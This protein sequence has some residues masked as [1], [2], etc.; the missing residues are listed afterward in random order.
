MSGAGKEVGGFTEG[1]WHVLEAETKGRSRRVFTVF[2]TGD[3]LKYI[4]YCDD[5]LYFYKPT[6][7]RANANL[8]AAAPDLLEALEL[9]MQWIKAW[10]VGF[11][12]DDDWAVDEARI[13]AAIHRARTGEV[14]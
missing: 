12:F 1:P 8:I 9:A 2:A 14:S 13:T 7:N 10:D 11:L 5:G 6:D 4:A 3:E